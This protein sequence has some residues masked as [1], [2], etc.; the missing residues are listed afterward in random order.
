MK[1]HLVPVLA[2]ALAAVR[3]TAQTPAP[4]APA[5]APSPAPAPA[6]ASDLKPDPALHFGTLPNG[7]RYL[8]MPNHEP[9]ERASLR[10]L[11]QAGSFQE[12][13]EQRGLAHFLEHMAFNGS[14]HY[15]PGTLVERLQRLGMAF[16]AD[17]NAATTFDHTVYQLELPQSTQATLAEGVQILSDYAG[18]LLIK[19]EMIDKE[20][21]IILSE[22]RTRDSSGYRSFVAETEF[23][24]GTT[25]IPKRLP[26]G[27]TAVIE[28]SGRD[29]FVSFYNTWYRPELMVVIAV[30]DFDAQAMEKT[31]TDL[32]SPLAARAP[33][34]PAVDLGS[35]PAQDKL[36]VSFHPDPE[37][38]VT[39]VVLSSVVPQRR[40]PDNAFT[41]IRELN[42]DVALAVL[43]R[44]LDVLSK[45]DKAPFIH[46]QASVGDQFDLYREAR[47]EVTCKPEQWQAAI[48]VAD[49]E[50]RKA[51]TFGFQP[52]EVMEVAADMKTDLEQ[53]AKSAS[54]RRSEDLAQELV[55][56]VMEHQVFTHPKD[57]LELLGP[58]LDK[59]SP[60]A[61]LSTLRDAWKSLGRNLFV[62]GNAKIE[63]DAGAAIEAAYR[64]SL[65]VRVIP[66]AALARIRWGYPDFGAPGTVAERHHVDDL[67]F[68]E[69]VLGNGV[70]LNI[71]KTDFEAHT[72]HVSAR[73]GYGQLT[74]PAGNEPGLSVFSSL[75]Y[76][77]G[78]LGKHSFDD[79][80]RVLAGHNV[81]INFTSTLDTFVVN[82][83]T[84]Q[85]D[86]ALEFQLFTASL[87]DPGYRPEA[88]R[89]AKKKI[90]AAYTQFEHTVGGAM[91]LHVNNQLASG[92]PRFGFPGKDEMLKRSLAEEKAWLSPVLASAPLEVTVV[93][94]VDEEA[95]IRTALATVGT[96][97]QRSAWSLDP[98]LLKVSYPQKPFTSEYAFESQIPKTLVAVYWPCADGMDIRR[99]RR[100][101][102]LGMVLGDRLRVKV[103]EQLGGTY[104][105]SVG[106]S[107]SDVIPGYGYYAAIVIVDPAK[108]KDIQAA[109]VD[110]A[111]DLYQHGVTQDELD[112]A[113]NPLLTSVKE[114]ERTNG[115]WL[116]ALGRAQEKPEVLDWARSRRA[117][118]ESITTADLS[119]LAKASFAPQ[120]ASRVIVRPYPPA[121]TPAP[122]G[123]PTP[124]PDGL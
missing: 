80:Q 93:G 15:P 10:L 6:P 45:K 4:S 33:A 94:D 32:F 113:K 78:G 66:D 82:G 108:A 112:R 28:K 116:T 68:T 75:T 62:T 47:I 101:N 50:L 97:P 64:H 38:A 117:D 16:G 26:I 13:E 91:A 36:R 43:N 54:T 104:S 83:D 5:P 42:R 11:V 58:A 19:P 109:V 25:R 53:A 71:K 100:L 90:E 37:A 98:A 85:E 8:V 52:N 7:V 79:L 48:E 60:G 1:R 44:R 17:T 51:L 89:A 77:P 74:E 2:L 110:V 63:G 73:L 121:P 30:G 96:L 61:C 31:I 95:V 59:I 46:A 92:D 24:L 41:R 56:S 115:Y 67:D 105:P 122:N 103:R 3:L 34:A 12:T 118:F 69:V 21:G 49:Q 40:L 22:K 111:A 107:A 81:G 124:P 55:E 18:G 9:K 23:T 39:R 88:A 119:A 27:E 35:V 14:T 29:P 87:T 106:C 20:R 120:N 102:V 76:T 86:L 65:T 114:S 123:A 70:R 99:A 57:D 72:V 84:T